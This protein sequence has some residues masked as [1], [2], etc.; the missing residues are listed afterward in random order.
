ML[1]SNQEGSLVAM[2]GFFKPESYDSLT[3]KNS[4]GGRLRLELS[5][6][7][8]ADLYPHISDSSGEVAVK[9]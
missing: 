5:A 8:A 3:H 4:H 9:L 1:L 6:N 2:N 7:G